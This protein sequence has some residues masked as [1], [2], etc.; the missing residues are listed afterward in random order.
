MERFSLAPVTD[1]ARTNA[2]G[3]RRV[4]GI[5]QRDRLSHMYI[6]GKTGTGKSTLLERLMLSD[7]EA[8]RGLA[9]VDP[10]G[11]LAERIA[12]RIPEH[13]KDDQIYL[14]VPDRSQPFGYNPLK[15]VVP[16]R[17][18]LAG[19][20]RLQCGISRGRHWRRSGS[21]RRSWR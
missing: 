5:K 13:R 12:A 14:N 18:P 2:R 10:H 15:R 11:D 1:F 4:F 19:E 9:L 7:I 21:W 6:I 3:D 8:G 17:R 16:E 20:R